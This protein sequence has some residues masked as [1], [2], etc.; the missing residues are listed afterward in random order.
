MLQKFYTKTAQM[1]NGSVVD[2]CYYV[3]ASAAANL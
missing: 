1:G 2:Y 3:P